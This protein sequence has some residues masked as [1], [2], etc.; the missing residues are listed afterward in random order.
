MIMSSFEENNPD[1]SKFNALV[2]EFKKRKRWVIVVA[3]PRII[4]EI[5][6]VDYS[7]AGLGNT[8]DKRN[9]EISRWL[10]DTQF[11]GNRLEKLFL[12]CMLENI[13]QHVQKGVALAVRQ[14][15]KTKRHRRYSELSIVDNGSGFIDEKGKRI[16][17]AEA[18]KWGRPRGK[19]GSAGQCLPLSLGYRANLTLIKIPGE[20]AIVQSRRHKMQTGYF[21]GTEMIWKTSNTKTYGTSISGYF[22]ENNDVD[23]WQNELIESLISKMK[24]HRDS[25]TAIINSSSPVTDEEYTEDLSNIFNLVNWQRIEMSEGNLGLNRISRFGRE[26]R[27]LSEE[28]YTYRGKTLYKVDRGQMIAAE[29]EDGDMIGAFDISYCTGLLLTGNR[30]YKERNHSVVIVIYLENKNELIELESSF[31]ILRN[32]GIKDIEPILLAYNEAKRAIINEILERLLSQKIRAIDEMNSL[33]SSRDLYGIRRLIRKADEYSDCLV[34][35]REIIIRTS[36]LERAKEDK[37]VR[38]FDTFTLTTEFRTSSPV[39]KRTVSK[40]SVLK[41][42][43]LLRK[44]LFLIREDDS[45]PSDYDWDK[46]E[47]ELKPILSDFFDILKAEKR[48]VLSIEKFLRIMILVAVVYTPGKEADKLIEMIEFTKQYTISL[49]WN[50]SLDSIREEI[51]GWA[52]VIKPRESFIWFLSGK[53]KSSPSSPS[54]LSFGK[55]RISLRAGTVLRQAQHGSKHGERSRTKRSRSTSSPVVHVDNSRSYT[56]VTITLPEA[57]DENSSLDAVEIIEKHRRKLK[58]GRFKISKNDKERFLVD[59]CIDEVDFYSVVEELISNAIDGSKQKLAKIQ[60]S[61]VTDSDGI[62]KIVFTVENEGGINYWLLREKAVSLREELPDIPDK[63]LPFIIGLSTKDGARG[64]G[65]FIVRTLVEGWGETL[66]IES[67][68]SAASPLGFLIGQIKEARGQNFERILLTLRSPP[69]NVSFYVILPLVFITIHFYLYLTYIYRYFTNPDNNLGINLLRQVSIEGRGLSRGFGAFPPAA[70]SK[71][72]Q[73]ARRN[74]Q[75]EN[76]SSSP[77]K[78]DKSA[79]TKQSYRGGRKLSF[80]TSLTLRDIETYIHK[81]ISLEYRKPIAEKVLY[82]HYLFFPHM[83]KDRIKQIVSGTFVGRFSEVVKMQWEHSPLRFIIVVKRIIVLFS[84]LPLCFF[85]IWKA[86]NALIAEDLNAFFIN[87]LGASL[88]KITFWIFSAGRITNFF[89]SPGYDPTMRCIIYPTS[90]MPKRSYLW[91]ESSHAFSDQNDFTTYDIFIKD[92]EIVQT[93]RTEKKEYQIPLIP[94]RRIKKIYSMNSE[95]RVNCMR[96]MYPRFIKKSRKEKYRPEREFTL[97]AIL[98]FPENYYDFLYLL[99]HTFDFDLAMELV[100]LLVRL[101]KAML[102]NDGSLIRVFK[103]KINEVKTDEKW[104]MT[105]RMKYMLDLKVDQI[106][107]DIETLKL[108]EDE[109]K[110]TNGI[111]FPKHLVKK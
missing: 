50:R 16:S 59:E 42:L 12:E 69:D 55:L 80:K 25:S 5:V 4:K 31:A 57:Q 67:G 28:L 21:A 6:E 52:T 10:S 24:T 41:R 108:L 1:W 47:R 11:T 105:E 88:A 27:S 103:G 2:N 22:Y 104:N 43:L 37:I 75:Y 95:Q 74:T 49:L 92:L 84:L 20:S 23:E 86:Y 71:N 107:Y 89:I 100:E 33:Q 7:F 18:I 17:I 34:D 106:V 76:G 53:N 13:D 81:D 9:E 61:R 26:E 39:G 83:K 96:K 77:V 82:M 45:P 90:R 46:D 3:G 87:F 14:E 91:H 63:E 109:G 99:T 15:R 85:C 102:D 64:L 97:I 32:L 8:R 38:R 62:R 101:R 79:E 54:A 78:R 93:A 60:L 94:K 110:V 48:D 19:R 98:Q 51:C 68:I 111:I 58:G 29:L 44:E 40:E 70:P 66:K 56:K 72:S 30:I 73:Y 36:R 65:L 35:N